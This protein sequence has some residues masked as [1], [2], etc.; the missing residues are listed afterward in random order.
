[1]EENNIPYEPSFENVI[2]A[3]QDFDTPF[4]SKYLY[5]LSDLS[6]SELDQLKAVWPTL[7]DWRRQAFLEDLEKMYATDTLLSFE[8]I[9]RLGLVDTHPQVRFIALRSLQDYEVVDLVPHFLQLLNTDEDLELRALAASILGQYIY[10]GEIEEIP[11]DTLDSIET[12]LLQAAQH[13]KTNLIRRRALESLGF[14]SRHE[15]P[16]LIETAFNTQEE[17]WMA[18]ALNAMGRTY[19]QRWSPS[20]LKMLQH[21]S[22]E[23]RF[24]A[25]RAAGEL[26]IK[27]AIE[28]LMALLHQE[29]KEIFLAA[30]WALSQIGGDGIQQ[31][32]EDLLSAPDS[33]EEAEFIEEALD[34]LVFN[35][36]IGLYGPFDFNDE[37]EL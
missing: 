16:A 19:D 35:E 29:D 15:V 11:P 10:L 7:P 27:N 14:S 25:V 8:E 1:M 6:G 21:P 37:F 36:S 31:V 2:A 13:G 20:V 3:L 12:S 28:P 34:N 32:F 17:N 9:C 26:E 4:P 30:V 33:A 22:P 18:S 24:E 23:I 5:R